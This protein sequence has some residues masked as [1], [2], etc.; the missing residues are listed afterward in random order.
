MSHLGWGLMVFGMVFVW[1][2]DA[3]GAVRSAFRFAGEKATVEGSSQGW[4]QTS[5][6][7]NDVPVYET[8]YSFR[9]IDGL[10]LS[11]VS[12]QTGGYVEA[13]Q[14]VTVQYVVSRPETSRI[15]GMR[16]SRA[17]FG[18]LFVYIFPVLGLALAMAGVRKGLRSRHLMSTG[19]LALGR[20]KSKEPTST[21]INNQT[22]YRY[23]FEFDAA[24]GG[25]YEVVGKTH[26]THQL[27]DE[28]LERIV[29]DPRDPNQATLLD[30]LPCR[31]AIDARGDFTTEGASQ[32]LFAALNLV[33]PALTVAV[34]V[35]YALLRD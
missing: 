22:V 31:P 13:S 28:D 16:A 6:S 21:R 11:G 33:L 19:E 2:F 14:S 35:A 29:Y 24:G 20:Q 1:A 10:E 5:L 4:R 8:S 34:Y 12:Y 26:R 32:L 3:G 30:E 18:V 17:G 25:T 15:Q 7:I 23:T 27:E 9:S